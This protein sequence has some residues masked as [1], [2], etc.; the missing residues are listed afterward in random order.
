MLISLEDL[1]R[2][3]RFF[4]RFGNIAVLIGRLLPVVRSVIA[5][6]AGLARMPLI[7]FHIYTF[8]GSWPFCYVL[9]L[10]GRKLGE[11]WRTDPRI[12]AV[13]HKL[14]VVVLAAIV[15]GGAWFVWHRVR[16]ARGGRPA[17]K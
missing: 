16:Q 14:D 13:F 5:Y 7:P 3:E 17:G 9:A 10:V 11:A 15:I 12:E 2:A 4:A 1:D 6:P 8:V